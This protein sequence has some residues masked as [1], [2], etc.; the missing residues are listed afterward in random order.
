MDE[1]SGET[2]HIGWSQDKRGMVLVGIP[3][4][5]GL[6][7]L[8][9]A[10]VVML[11]HAPYMLISIVIAA[12]VVLGTLV[13]AYRDARE[14]GFD[15]SILI[16]FLW[17]VGYPTHMAQRR[18]R[19]MY[20]G[21][22]WAWVAIATFLLMPIVVLVGVAMVLSLASHATSTPGTPNT[23]SSPAASMAAAAETVKCTNTKC[24]VL[25]LTPAIVTIVMASKGNKHIDFEPAST[26]EDISTIAL[27]PG[28]TAISIRSHRT[29]T[30]LAPLAALK[31]LTSVDLHGSKL[32]SLEPLVGLPLTELDLGDAKGITDFTPLASL[33]TLRSLIV[34]DAGLSSL[35]SIRGLTAM[36][37]LD[38]GF[39]AHLA[40]VAGI[41]ALQNLEDL[42]LFA[43]RLADL[44][45]IA[46]L[47]ALKTLRIGGAKLTT[48]APF[49]ALVHLH[50]LD[51]SSNDVTDLSP[52]R[53][54]A[55]LQTLDIS[56]NQHLK[57]L[58]PIGALPKL[59]YLL[60]NR[61]AVE[62]LVTIGRL[63]ALKYISLAPHTSV[64]TIVSLGTVKTLKE[65]KVP[66]DYPEADSE[67]F[68]K[69]LPE[70]KVTRS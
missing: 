36:K 20:F 44:M 70:V 62:T 33:A 55:E 69:L 37:K 53:G 24:T 68:R 17:V 26:N 61:S 27:L 54:M 65:V 4:A 13:V 51:V 16:L 14:L 46:K 42:D 8:I 38:A 9:A 45:P 41:E 7:N 22:G 15:G 32:K 43:S 64:K 11:M 21:V 67:G 58:T 2:D 1:W 5:G 50:R 18:R 40:S 3:I 57:D 48:L 63:P 49:A 35:D 60:V 19:G 29:E 52:L 47:T 6:L 34:Y 56:E 10:P 12:L 31:S 25:R 39:N 30:D 28:V 59:E 23:T 66:K